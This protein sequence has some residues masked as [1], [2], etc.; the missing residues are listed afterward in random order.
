MRIDKAAKIWFLSPISQ[1][2][3]WSELYMLWLNF[4]IDDHLNKKQIELKKIHKYH[5]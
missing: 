5:K 3:V 2:G 1:S 4:F